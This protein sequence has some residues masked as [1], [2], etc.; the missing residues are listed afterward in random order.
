MKVAEVHKSSA[1]KNHIQAKQQ[2]FF[3]KEGENGFFSK[4]NEVTESFFSPTIVQPKLTIGQPND[5]HELE[6][7]A[8]ADQVIQRLSEPNSEFSHLKESEDNEV[9]TKPLNTLIQHKCDECEHEEKLQKKEEDE[10]SEKD[11]EIQKKPNVENTLEKDQAEVQTRSLDSNIIQNKCNE[12]EHEEKLQKKE[13][14]EVSET[15][16]E[17]QEKPIFESNTEQ[18]E[19]EIQTK[20]LLS[21]YNDP[22]S[23]SIAEN[24]INNVDS[25]Q[26]KSIINLQSSNISTTT[27]ESEEKIQ[28][29]ENE[30]SDS[31][32]EIHTKLSVAE[33]PPDDEETIQ[34]KSRTSQSNAS[35]D[36]QSRLNSSKGGGSPLSSDLQ[37]SMGTAFGADFSNVRIHT[38]SNAVEMSKDLGAQAFTHGSDIYFNEGKYDAKSNSGKHLL[39]H[40]LTHTV[41]Q[42]AS[43]VT[44]S[45]QK[46]SWDDVR[47][48]GSNALSSARRGANYVGGAISNAVSSG[49]ETVRDAGATFIRSTLNRFAPGL[50]DML[51]NGIDGEL[52]KRIFQSVLRIVRSIKTRIEN[53]DLVKKIKAFFSSSKEKLKQWKNDVGDK[54]NTLYEKIDSLVTFLGEINDPIIQQIRRDLQ[55]LGGFAS[56]FWDNIGKPAWDAIKKFAGNAWSWL[57]STARWIWDRTARIRQLFSD[58]WEWIKTQLGLLQ[59]S[60]SSIW[61]R[62]KEIATEV[63]EEIKSF[64]EPVLGPLKVLGGLMLMFSPLG[65]VVAIYQGGPRIWESLKWV[66]AN[67]SGWQTLIDLKDQFANEILPAIS[68]GAQLAKLYL[69][70]AVAWVNGIVSSVKQA[71]KDFLSSIGVLQ[72]VDEVRGF[73]AELRLLFNQIKAEFDDL[74]T[75]LKEDFNAVMN[76]AK[77]VL[78]SLWECIRPITDFILGI[79]AIVI[80]P[81]MW[82]IYAVGLI[83]RLAWYFLPRDLKIVA[84]DYII[85]L[86]RGAIEYFRPS[87]II[88]QIWGVFRSGAISFLDRLDAYT[89][90][91]KIQFI[92]KILN[93]IIDPRTYGAYMRGLIGGFLHQAWTLVSGIISL[94]IEMPNIIQGIINFFRNLVPDIATVE[95]MLD[96]ITEISNRLQEL[97]ARENLMQY[98]VDTIMNAPQTLADWITETIDQ[99]AE[100]AENTGRQMAERLFNFVNTMNPSDVGYRIGD[101]VGRLL[102]EILLTKGI[103]FV[104]GK[105]T[106]GIAWFRRLL[107]MLRSGARNAAS[108]LMQRIRALF[109]WIMDRMRA[110]FRRLGEALGNIFDS[111]KRLIDDIIAWIM[112][113]VR[114]GGRM[115]GDIAQNRIRWALFERTVR[116][117][118]NSQRNPRGFRRRVA[119]NMF[120]NL[121]AGFRDVARMPRIMPVRAS[122]DNDHV[123]LWELHAVK[124][125]GVNRLGTHI[126]GYLPMPRNVAYQENPVIGL[127]DRINDHGERHRFIIEGD[128]ANPELVVRSRRQVL[129][130]LLRRRRDELNDSN[131]TEDNIANKRQV[132]TR[133]FDQENDLESKIGEYKQLVDRIYNRG[134]DRTRS[135]Q[136]TDKYDEVR[137]LVGQIG[138]NLEI[139]GIDSDNAI[140]ETQVNFTMQRGRARLMRAQ[141]LTKIPPGNGIIPSRPIQDPLGFDLIDSDLRRRGLWVRAHLLSHRIHGPGTRNNLFPG[142]KQMNEDYMRDQ[143]ETPLRTMLW[144]QDRIMY[145]IVGVTYGNTG[146]FEDIPTA[147]SLEYGDFD[148]DTGN[149]T[150]I[151]NK[152]FHQDPPDVA[153]PLNSLNNSRASSLNQIARNNGY[154]RMGNFFRRL[155]RH[156]TTNS[157]TYLNIGHIRNELTSVYQDH[158]VLDQHITNLRTMNTMGLIRLN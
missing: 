15:D 80:N 12:C 134:T 116:L 104:I 69:R 42:G 132:V 37:T 100:F 137:V 68:K 133:L 98:I 138:D 2:P 51:S 141:P 9:Q 125:F 16:I 101:I 93:L 10:V 44:P 55:T 121:F 30:L 156:R 123:G 109:T 7:D 76:L 61:D 77:D 19:S 83:A 124:R 8:M 131:N 25:L 49:V 145:Y 148:P 114:G 46:L 71:V 122:H 26:T 48:A 102:F 130:R 35:A 11:L 33:T 135:S 107:G 23:T 72:A 149:R 90:D 84:I 50:Y 64:I 112:R 41:Q 21:V 118:T 144:N 88:E 4:Y 94:S 59:D 65:P 139:V 70:Q 110:L 128:L 53:S 120:R 24:P 113:A 5:K 1:A 136:M 78:Q 62:F 154:D 87:G 99:G 54:C 63:W 66:V 117:F 85:E 143:V 96:R 106:Q 158:N 56:S 43:D 36:L 6:A 140:V 115:L 39:A 89:P 105:I 108:S 45:V 75:S 38:G 32:E 157:I 20:P 82:P 92:D 79:V 29:K 127:E 52:K 58:I 18:A 67:W 3:K 31:R 119:K 40:E 129:I 28:E 13:E 47:Q 60:A 147:V 74:Y 17:L 14:E 95:R 81:A 97:L 146:V 27:V 34:T 103:G 142:S 150:R 111:F 155:V 86:I 73:M 57:Q 151:D 126:V 91:E 22:V 152:R 153:A